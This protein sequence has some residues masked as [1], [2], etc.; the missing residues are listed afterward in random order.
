M[1]KFVNIFF[2]FLPF[3]LLFDWKIQKLK[4]LGFFLQNFDLEHRFRRIILASIFINFS[5]AFSLAVG[6]KWKSQTYMEVIQIYIII[7]FVTWKQQKWSQKHLMTK[8]QI[9]CAKN[10]SLTPKL[11]Q[12]KI[13]LQTKNRQN[14]E[15]GPRMRK[16]DTSLLL[17]KILTRSKVNTKEDRKKYFWKWKKWFK[18][19]PPNSAGVIT[20]RWWRLIKAY[21]RSSSTMG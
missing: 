3:L 9:F 2:S 13:Q 10:T 5:F 15:S 20:R 18:Q 21:S 7:K 1:R 8:S 6:A 19:N 14:T 11:Q 4:N 17:R 16:I 12:S